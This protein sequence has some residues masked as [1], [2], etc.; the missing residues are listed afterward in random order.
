M[1]T[2]KLCVLML[3]LMGT[4]SCQKMPEATAEESAGNRAEKPQTT[5]GTQEHPIED[6]LP[7]SYT[8]DS[9]L[10]VQ[11]VSMPVFPD[12]EISKVGKTVTLRPLTSN[13]VW[14][15]ISFEKDGADAV[16]WSELK[17]VKTTKVN[18]LNR[19]L[20][21]TKETTDSGKTEIHGFIGVDGQKNFKQLV[22][23]GLFSEE[24]EEGRKR[25]GQLWQMV[26]WIFIESDD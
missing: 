15:K 24:D 10:V 22:I 2:R 1:Q 17:G 16:Y 6:Y 3:V 5:A 4:V 7:D 14:L 12:W 8:I 18:G 20:T 25:A 26:H 13:S 11:G 23:Q 9:I 19:E 21:Y